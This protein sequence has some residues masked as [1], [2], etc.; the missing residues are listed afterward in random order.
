MNYFEFCTALAEH[1]AV[2]HSGVVAGYWVWHVLASNSTWRTFL[3]GREEDAV[4][5]AEENSGQGPKMEVMPRDP[6]RA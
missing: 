4:A 2:V 5:W 6:V 3:D 1:G